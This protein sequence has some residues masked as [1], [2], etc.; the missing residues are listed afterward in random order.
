[1]L[2]ALHKTDGKRRT[3]NKPGRL[4]SLL[5]S[6]LRFFSVHASVFISVEMRICIVFLL[7]TTR[8]DKK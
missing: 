8:R 5:F 7:P 3:W 4:K 1:M 6:P 2:N